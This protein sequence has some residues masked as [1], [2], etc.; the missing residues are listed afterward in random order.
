MHWNA[1]PEPGNLSLENSGSK[2]IGF[3]SRNLHSWAQQVSNLC[4]SNPVV[5]KSFEFRIFTI[6]NLQ[7]QMF[8]Q[9][10]T[11]LKK[12]QHKIKDYASIDT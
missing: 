4:D 1:I 7:H 8:L 9:N 3:H 12:K 6:I 11:K 5:N 2:I 10:V